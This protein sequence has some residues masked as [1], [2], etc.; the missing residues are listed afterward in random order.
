MLQSCSTPR[1]PQEVL[2]NGLKLFL[3][4]DKEVPLVRGTLLMRGGRHAEPASTV[5]VASLAAAVQRSGGSVAHPGK[6]LDDR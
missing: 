6:E 2:P 1:L 5:G 3:L 4:V